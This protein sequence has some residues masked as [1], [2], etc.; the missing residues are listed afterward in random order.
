MIIGEKSAD[1]IGGI[2]MSEDA[3]LKRLI[4]GDD[5]KMETIDNN[6]RNRVKSIDKALDVLL[7]FSREENELAHCGDRKADGVDDCL[8]HPGLSELSWNGI[9]SRRMRTM[10]NT[11]WEIW[12]ITWEQLPEA[13][14]ICEAVRC[15]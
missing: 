3:A 5:D 15:R 8:R 4:V 1:F 12:C 10:A 2:P 6:D 13:T 7:L 14:P 9:F 11:A